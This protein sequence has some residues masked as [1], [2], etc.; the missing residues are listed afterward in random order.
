CCEIPVA[1]V[2]GEEADEYRAFLQDYN[3]YWRTYFDPIALR[4]QVNPDRYRLETIVLPLFDNS[5]YTGLAHF[6][7]GKPAPLDALP[8]PTRNI[9]SVAARF[10][11][12]ALLRD[13]GIDE[14]QPTTDSAENASSRRTAPTRDEV[15]CQNN[16][17]QIGLALHNYH[18]AYGNFPPQASFDKSGK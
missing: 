8:V 12:R 5:I 10:N 7:G 4:I 3:Q 15:Q 18:D 9:F 11:R 17:R 13:A 14:Q 6:L 16:L 2:K 1:Q